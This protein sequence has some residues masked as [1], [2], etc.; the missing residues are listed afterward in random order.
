MGGGGENGG[1]ASLSHF[2][3]LDM[4]ALA[5]TPLMVKDSDGS[6]VSLTYPFVPESQNPVITASQAKEILNC[7][8]LDT[9][10]DPG[11][12]FDDLEP[13]NPLEKK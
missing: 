8:S 12:L 13:L 2:G 9:D 3:D 1:D 10:D 11:L 4:L 5:A 6:D 7:T